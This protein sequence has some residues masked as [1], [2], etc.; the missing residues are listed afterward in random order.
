MPVWVKFRNVP[1]VAFT[2]DGLSLMATK[3]GRPIMLD[4][5]TSTMCLESCGRN[6]SVRALIKI[7]SERDLVEYLV[8]A[9]PEL[10]GSGFTR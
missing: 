9:I 8:V 4:A 7:T 10:D 1:I 5:Y 6:S 3:I 2:E